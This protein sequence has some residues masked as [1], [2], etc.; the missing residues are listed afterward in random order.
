MEMKKGLS[1]VS[2]FVSN[3][4]SNDGTKEF[5]DSLTYKWLNIKHQEENRGFFGNIKYAFN[6]PLASEFTWIIGDDDYIIPGAIEGILALIEQ[7]PQAD[8]I[9]C[10]TKAFPSEQ[11]EQ[12]LENFFAVGSIE[13]GTVKS[14]KYVGTGLVHFENLIDPEIADTLLG[15]LMCNCF[16]TSAVR[17]P[18]NP[19]HAEFLR[20]DYDDA[21]LESVGEFCQPHNLPLLNSFKPDTAAVY[22]D[23]VRTF[24]FWGSAE[25]LT[26]YDYVF[27]VIILYLISDYYRRGF[28]KEEKYKSLLDY[29]Y[30]TM[31]G[32]LFRQATGISTARPF[33]PA[34][35]LEMFRVFS[36]YINL[37]SN[38]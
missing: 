15:E 30:R 17:F 9:F 29:Y 32:P 8:Y 34:V 35:K 19:R 26:D 2:V 14:Q 37:K 23:A 21:G 24:N 38:L 4:C 20:F 25:W 7:Y 36:I 11:A 22:C 3:N 16:R 13:G 18:E 33:S 27:P 6:I 28:V 12:I 31:R 1:G 5:L 10:N